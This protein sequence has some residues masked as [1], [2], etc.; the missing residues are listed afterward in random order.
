MFHTSH[1]QIMGDFHLFTNSDIFV[2]SLNTRVSLLKLT[3]LYGDMKR[4]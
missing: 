3:K 2:Q 4:M 1:T